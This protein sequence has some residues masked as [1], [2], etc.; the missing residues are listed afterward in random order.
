MTSFHPHYLNRRNQTRTIPYS[1]YSYLNTTKPKCL[2]FQKISLDH[3]SDYLP[4]NA[5][6]SNKIS[7]KNISFYF[8][9]LDEEGK[10][11]I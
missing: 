5:L 8:N 4:P 7:L 2:L 11:S 9:I 3:L 10:K 1:S 6:N